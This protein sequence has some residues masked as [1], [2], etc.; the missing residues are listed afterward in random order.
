MKYDTYYKHY[1]D[2][3]NPENMLS[4]GSQTQKV[5]YCTIPSI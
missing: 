2:W 5:I 3:K 1:A 4:E